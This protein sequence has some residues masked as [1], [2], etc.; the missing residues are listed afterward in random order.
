MQRLDLRRKLLESTEASAIPDA[1]STWEGSE[2]RLQLPFEEIATVARGPA[3]ARAEL[4]DHLS[5]R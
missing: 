4:N 1:G 3:W 5:L 2:W